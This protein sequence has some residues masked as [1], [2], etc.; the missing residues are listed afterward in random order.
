MSVWHF[1]RMILLGHCLTG[2]M[3][4]SLVTIHILWVDFFSTPWYSAIRFYT[5][6]SDIIIVVDLTFIKLIKISIKQL[7]ET[8]ISKH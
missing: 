4:H 3:K 2:V 8:N 5:L 6:A 1:L 7:I